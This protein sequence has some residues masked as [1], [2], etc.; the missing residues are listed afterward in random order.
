ML[1]SSIKNMLK[2]MG[3]SEDKLHKAQNVMTYK[4]LLN[5]H[6]FDLII[7]SYM[8]QRKILGPKY[9]YLYQQSLA[10]SNHCCFMVISNSGDIDQLRGAEELEPDN[11]LQHPF[12]FNELK[13]LVARSLVKR[14]VLAMV[15][16]ELDAGRY[17]EAIELCNSQAKRKG[18]EWLDCHKVVVDCYIRQN[19]HESAILL[20]EKLSR[21]MKHRWPLVKLISL[22]DELGNDLKA[23]EHAHE[24]ELLGY[25]DDPIVSQVTARHSLIN[26]HLDN[27]VKVMVKLSIRYPHIVHLT[28]KCV[29]LCIMQSDYRKANM[30]LSK[31]DY[32]SV[33][34]DE[35]LIFIEEL[36]LFVEALTAIKYQNR[37]NPASLKTGLRA[38]LAVGENDS[39]D[40]HKFSKVLY[41]LV[42][43]LNGF[44]PVC[45]PKRLD[46]LYTQTKL[47]HR[48]FVLLAV[49]LHI[50]C[51]DIAEGWIE[52]LRQANKSKKDIA[53]TISCFILDQAQ[54]ILQSKKRVISEA[55]QQATLGDVVG[56][57]AIKAKEAPY[58]I[59]HHSQF[60]NAMLKFK[61]ADYTNLEL[62]KEQFPISVG[63]VIANLLKQDP[64]HP[65]VDQIQQAKRVV[66]RRLHTPA[67]A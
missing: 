25:P 28:I 58:Y 39:I 59:S 47:E 31:I 57:L 63:I 62:L 50:G 67:T 8:G 55:S 42:L 26:S 23:L 29:M 65:K 36:R 4:Q 19:K 34:D 10:F 20:L 45:S 15:H 41:Q 60:I 33:L 48:K 53:M 51:L 17:D 49:A 21:Q 5:K 46:T 14:S 27:A 24:Y 18:I 64:L 40:S 38:I 66:Q 54:V 11:I 6:K 12:N 22:Y 9:H 61:S 7:C 35:E 32:D 37:M 44:N 3:G 56:S 1:S 16:K 52:E 2:R 43:Q 13:D 30:F